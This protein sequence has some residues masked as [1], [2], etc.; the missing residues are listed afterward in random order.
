MNIHSGFNNMRLGICD[1]LTTTIMTTITTAFAFIQGA[2]VLSLSYNE[3]MNIGGAV[4]LIIGIVLGFTSLVIR[5][6]KER[7]ETYSF[8]KQHPESEDEL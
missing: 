7:R 5:I 6:R 1:M 2:L 4:S 3:W 8:R